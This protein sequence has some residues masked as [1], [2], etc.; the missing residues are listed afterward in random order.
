MWH[1][2]G[3]H[4]VTSELRS[5]TLLQAAQQARHTHGALPAA[6]GKTNHGY[7]KVVGTFPNNCRIHATV[8]SPQA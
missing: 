3:A 7:A 4:S 8:L 6:A 5:A 1:R 2:L